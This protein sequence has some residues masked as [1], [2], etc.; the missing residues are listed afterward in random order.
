MLT[1]QDKAYAFLEFRSIEEASNCMALDGVKFQ[2]NYLKVRR[3]NN[4]DPALAIILGPSEPSPR[5]DLSGFEIVRTVVEVSF[6]DQSFCTL[7]IH[8]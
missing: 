3:P 6:V 1:L 8:I 4:Y 5:V 2:G 7:Y